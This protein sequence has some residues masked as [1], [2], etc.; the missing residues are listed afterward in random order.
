M[1]TL[2]QQ[3]STLQTVVRLRMGSTNDCEEPAFYARYLSSRKPITKKLPA[4]AAVENNAEIAETT[5]VIA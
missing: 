4:S 3:S 5:R 2:G 1:K